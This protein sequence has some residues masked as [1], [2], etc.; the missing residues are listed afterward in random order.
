MAFG[1]NMNSSNSNSYNGKKITV[2]PKKLLLV[3]PTYDEFTAT[4]G[5]RK[6]FTGFGRAAK[7]E[8]K[9]LSYF[10]RKICARA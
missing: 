3:M 5:D 9:D 4:S 8:H 6:C 2:P 10:P 1:V 7:I